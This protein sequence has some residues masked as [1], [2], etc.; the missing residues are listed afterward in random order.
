MTPRIEQLIAEIESLG[1]VFE[2]A[3]PQS[4]V[5]VAELE[6]TLGVKLPPSYRA[7]LLRYGAGGIQAY[8]GISG[9]YDNEP[10]SM[11]LGTTYGDTLR[12]RTDR[13]M[14]SHLIVIERGDEHFPP[15]CL[16]T[17]GPGPNGEYP[18]VGFW[19]ISRTISTD[20]YA[21]FAEY[22]EES[23]ATS[24]EVIRDEQG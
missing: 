2:W 23:L 18:V 10:L 1:E 8:D 22:L 9:I 4:E 11:Q 17:L 16:D 3:G 7:F 12:M 20:S 21:N 15:M 5:S 14:P 13:G 24:L 19:V 6:R